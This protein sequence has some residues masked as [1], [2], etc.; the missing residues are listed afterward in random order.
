M[1]RKSFGLSTN[2][3]NPDLSRAVIPQR[4]IVEGSDFIVSLEPSNIVLIPVK[5]SYE[6]A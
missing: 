1:G 6:F 2:D 3:S 5:F 4:I